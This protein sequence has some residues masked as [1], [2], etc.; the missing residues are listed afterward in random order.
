MC[1]HVRFTIVHSS[2]S[3][4]LRAI[5]GI[6]ALL[7]AAVSGRLI[8][9]RL[10]GA[11]F[12][13]SIRLGRRIRAE[14][15]PFADMNERAMF[16]V[17][18]VL[19]Q[20]DRLQGDTSYRS[21]LENH[22]KVISPEA[23]LFPNPTLAF[24]TPW[25][26]RGYD[27]AKLYGSKFSHISPVWFRLIPGD[28]D[29]QI[30]GQHDIDRGWLSDVRAANPNVS[31]VPRFLVEYRDLESAV[32]FVS[33]EKVQNKCFRMLTEFVQRNNFDG[34]V[35]EVY[36]QTQPIMKQQK[37]GKVGLLQ[38]VINLA[39]HLKAAGKSISLVV[40]PCNADGDQQSLFNPTDF[41]WVEPFVDFVVVMTYDYNGR[42][43][44][45]LGPPV[46]PLPWVRRCMTE[47]AKASP[48]S[49]EKL[50][51][52]IN[53]YGYLYDADKLSAEAIIGPSYLELL[54]EKEP[55]IQWDAE[56]AEHFTYIGQKVV[57]N[58]PSLE[59]VGS[60]IELAKEL[61]VGVAIWEI[62]QGLDHFYNLL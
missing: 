51:M 53:F 16:A 56:A 23:K 2:S 24:V 47:L 30:D 45:A 36:V 31:I 27:V 46:A 35:F 55:T 33:N 44:A 61:G 6:N 60:K 28:A 21:I 38:T 14:C 19:L 40:P 58:Y 11:F 3:H 41:R 25:N 7:L 52:G 17:L 29:C 34:V 9:R 57:T 15:F 8:R 26:G 20:L 37:M 13:N 54:R 1:A 39:E 59:A 48:S 18:W 42:N 32:N 49:S 4:R 5:T 43:A 22:D 50:L 12:E 10:I 62:G